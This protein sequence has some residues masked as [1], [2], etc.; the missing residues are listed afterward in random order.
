MKH[1]SKDIF[2]PISRKKQGSSA[3]YELSYC[4]KDLPLATLVENGYTMWQEDSL[5]VYIDDDA[6]LCAHYLPYLSPTHAP[7]GTDKFF[8][9]GVNY[10]TKAE[11][12]AILQRLKAD[13]PPYSAPLI[14]WLENGEEYNG[15]FF[16][17]I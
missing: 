2:L 11:T 16:L 5:L 10:Y 12:A 15:F 17:G 4:K 14:E 9:A 7:D 6:E 8:Y 13:N 1:K 3:Y